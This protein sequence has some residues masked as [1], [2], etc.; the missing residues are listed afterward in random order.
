MTS[1]WHEPVYHA[2][3]ACQAAALSLTAARL[4]GQ[5]KA[6][7]VA[8]KKTA[9]VFVHVPRLPR[10]PRHLR[11]STRM[12]VLCSLK[13][14]CFIAAVLGPHG[15][16]DP[17]PHIGKSS[18]RHRMALAFS[19]FALIVVSGPRFTVCGLPGKLVQGIA[20]RFDA[21]QASMRFGV[22]PTLKQHG[23]GSPQRLQTAGILVARAI[24]SDFGK[25]PW[26]QAFACTWQARK[27]LVV[28][29]GQKKGANLLVI[30]PDLLEQW[31]QLTHQH[32]HQT[33][34]GAGGD[35]IGPQV[36]LLQPLD[37][38]GGDRDRMGMFGSSKH[39]GD[40]FSRSGHRRLWRGVGL[41]EQQRTLLL[42]FS[43]QLQGHRVVG[44]AS[45][46]ELIDQPCLHLDQRILIAREQFQ[47]GELFAIW[48]EAMHIGQVCTSGLG[49]QVGVNGIRL[50]SR[51]GS[52][53]IDGA[54]IDRIDGPACFQQMSNQQ[55]MGRLNDAGHLVFRLRTNDLL[56]E[57]VQFG[58]ALRAVIDAQRADLKALRDFRLQRSTVV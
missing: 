48:R 58:H 12:L 23:R 9:G 28:L 19:S 39:L 42:Q 7:Q 38:L 55:A 24:I 53:T 49:Q 2:A 8:S 27:E 30:L 34:F 3:H 26:S 13:D 1:T 43:K 31:Q 20:Q 21:A 56:Q 50:G 29:M 11:C 54:R 25:P 5:N 40:L 46:S 15:K 52:S 57:G 36:R 4:R 47:L 22:H 18:H 37:N 45:G 17:D 16:D 14:G 6:C 35:S 10:K 51:C 32:Q 33:R 41:Q 44:Y